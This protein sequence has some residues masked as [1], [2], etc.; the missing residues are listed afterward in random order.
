MKELLKAAEVNER[1]K[2]YKRRLIDL[3]KYDT[4]DEDDKKHE[5]SNSRD[6]AIEIGGPCVGC[7]FTIQT[8]EEHTI[9]KTALMGV[10]NNRLLKSESEIDNLCK[11][12]I[13]DKENNRTTPE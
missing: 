13:N 6:V 10:M 9:L 1:T 11:K 12:R 8:R 5:R 4:L 7:K 3:F 2:E